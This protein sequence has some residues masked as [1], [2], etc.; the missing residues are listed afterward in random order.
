MV[1]MKSGGRTLPSNLVAAIGQAFAFH[2]RGNLPEARRCYRA[3][4][5]AQPAQFDVLHGCGVLEAQLAHYDE[6]HRLLSR[7]VNINPG[8]AEAHLNLGKTLASLNRPEEALKE[9]EAAL[10]LQ[11]DWGEALVLRAHALLGLNRYSE[12]VT[13][14]DLALA[15]MPHHAEALNHRGIALHHL[16]QHDEALASYG[17]A[18]A[19]AP[20]YADAFNNRAN[21]LRDLRRYE[22]AI[23]DFR[24]VLQLNPD[25]EYAAGALV[26]L[27]MQ[28]CDWGAYH[29]ESARVIA[30][31]RAGKRS[32]APFTFIGISDSARD[33]YLCSVICARDRFAAA[34]VPMRTRGRY[35]H[36]R[37]RVAYVSSDLHEH[38]TA[39][40]MAGLFERH[41]RA[42]FETTAVSLG[43]DQ[44]GAMRSRLTAAFGRFIE[45]RQKSDRE[46]AGMLRELEIDIA[47]DLK[48]FTQDGRTGIFAL[49]PAPVQV[50]YLGYPGT[51]GADY[52]DY[53]VADHCIIPA[54][55]H[56]YYAEK[57]V[58]LPDTYQVNDTQRRSSQR[59]PSHAEAGLPEHGFVFCSFNNSYKITPP[60]FEAWMLLLR[61]VEGS[62]LWLLADNAA[63][64]HNLRREAAARGV[65][66]ERLIF[67]DRVGIEDHLA[68]HRL[69]DLFL[70]TLP[71]NAHTTASDALWAGVPVLTLLG[72]TFAGRVAA[73]LLSAIGLPELVTHSLSEYQALAFKLATDAGM[74]ADIKAKLARN[75]ETHPLFDTDRFRRH[76]EAAYVTMWERC[77]RGKPPVSFAVEVI[78]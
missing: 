15:T 55:H 60:F 65:A 68:R 34:P 11:A 38:A 6:A 62:V 53:V 14:Y 64:T 56:G 1:R 5:K 29:E 70:D 50:N 58:Y 31:V 39:H 37:I 16:G 44:P 33:Q 25:Y 9:Y 67:A 66:P 74:H 18:L 17:K 24:R 27:K 40:L 41:D 73:S 61:E 23:S 7:A 63:A 30:N 54:E 32:I 69:A 26:G 42:R 36:D 75:R 77:Q 28:C 20:D 19:L 4:L 57:V 52:I 72:T 35:R 47:V 51:M 49:R 13:S 12:A 45:A 8:S 22:E 59:T 3:I 78:Q 48:G 46:I 10:A 43:P 21:A 76:I 2:Q 71:Y